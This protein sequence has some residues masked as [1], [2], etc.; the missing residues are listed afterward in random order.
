M[1]R[2]QGHSSWVTTVSFDQ[3]QCTDK[4][5]RFISGG[6]DTLLCFWD[7]SSVGLARPKG[8]TMPRTKSKMNLEGPTIH[9]LLTKSEVP[10]LEP[11]VIRKAHKHGIS[12]IA[13]CDGMFITVDKLGTIFTWK[14]E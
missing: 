10:I 5:Y 6:D 14:L 8:S 13:F 11:L 4:T 12:D 1:A 2:F 3:S 7:F 9:E